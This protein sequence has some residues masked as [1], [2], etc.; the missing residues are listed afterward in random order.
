MDV[1][2]RAS[3]VTDALWLPCASGDMSME[4]VGDIISCPDGLASPQN[5]LASLGEDD[6]L[7]MMTK[8]NSNKF[9]RS[10]FSSV[11]SLPTIMMF[12]FR[13]VSLLPRLT[14]MCGPTM[15]AEPIY[16]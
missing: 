7:T 5:V 3:C 10:S 15:S 12:L 16:S 9:V 6:M 13:E 11:C 4:I 1:L 2:R 8:W 14:G